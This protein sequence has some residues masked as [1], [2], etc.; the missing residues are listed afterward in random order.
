MSTAHAAHERTPGSGQRG[1][2]S[3][4]ARGSDDNT[5]EKTP[6][7]EAFIRE[8]E[9]L[10]AKLGTNLQKV[11][12]LG[13]R[14]LDLLKIYRLVIEA[15]GFDIV[16]DVRGWKRIG[17][18][19]DLPAT[20]TNSAYVFKQIYQKYLLAYERLNFVPTVTHDNIGLLSHSDQTLPFLGNSTFVSCNHKHNSSLSDLKSMFTILLP[21]LRALQILQ[22]GINQGRVSKRQ[23]VEMPMPPLA[24]P[25]LVPALKRKFPANFAV[26]PDDD[27]ALDEQY[28]QGFWQSRLTLALRSGLP[29]EVDWAYNK[30]IKLSHSHP[31]PLAKLPGL[32]DTL[33][34]HMRPFCNRLVLNTRPDNY[35]TSLDDQTVAELLSLPALSPHQ[36]TSHTQH[37]ST[38]LN[39]SSEPTCDFSPITGMRFFS[40]VETEIEYERV[41]QALHVIR[42]ISFIPDN[43][44]ILSKDH[45]LPSV[46]TKSI[47]LPAETLYIQA[48]HYALDILENIAPYTTLRGDMDFYLACLRRMVLDNDHSL[49]IGSLRTLNRFASN[50]Q[51][52]KTI[53]TIDDMLLQRLLQLLLVPDEEI[54]MCV[55]EFLY[56]F[57]SASS[58]ASM[59][60]VRC[61][62]FNVLR[63]LTKFLHWRGTGDVHGFSFASTIALPNPPPGF[64]LRGLSH[65]YAAMW[66][67]QIVEVS[68]PHYGISA[69][70]F[71][72]EYDAY[73]KAHNLTPIPHTELTKLVAGVFAA[74]DLAQLMMHPKF[75]KL[76]SSIL[77]ELK[78][79]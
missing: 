71:C 69:K 15:G 1:R 52:E 25:S 24:K 11:P 57:S 37:N 35:E 10:H 32:I 46:L 26:N 55:M 30:L 22:T 79:K 20:C 74:H 6:E 56:L 9:E 45:Q 19:F 28:L 63:L 34:D 49:V 50:E 60:M 3:T 75:A 77:A 42:N 66:I 73:C 68:G 39:S 13:G 4:G 47:A 51:N 53:L 18:H 48:K 17:V 59:R 44:V 8:L 38:T 36:S 21:P 14:R 54:V 61:V 41:L 16:T 58:E 7:Y 43:A 70:S 40:S 29:N 31:L 67:Q 2:Y 5:I 72:I 78:A 33:V 12:V 64:D 76:I 23:K 62:R 65:F 27:A